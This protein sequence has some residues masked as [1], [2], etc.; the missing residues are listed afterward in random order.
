MSKIVF[1]GA[2]SGFGQ[3]LC[4]D[5]LAH[6]ELREC[7]ICLVDTNERHLQSVHECVTQMI[8][9]HRL[10]ATVEAT[11]DRRA[12]LAGADYVVIAV[13]IGGPA[14]DGVPYYHEITIPARY[15]IYQEVGDTLGPGGVFRTLRS[16]PELMRMAQDIGEL[17]PRAWVL[18]YTNPMAALTWVMGATAPLNLV[19]LCHSVQGTA[20]QLAGFLGLPYS[21]VRYWVAGINHMSWFLEFTHDGE[22]LYPR[23]RQAMEDPAIY[24]KE[25]VR[26]EIMRHFGYFV[27]ES[28]RHM[29][30]YVPYFRKSRELLSEFGLNLREVGEV[31]QDRRWS[32]L[33]E[34]KQ[35]LQDADPNQDLKPS[36]EYASYI[37]KAIETNKPFRFNGNVM[38]GGLI[39]NLPP[40]CCVEVPCL[41]DGSGVRPCYVGALPTHLAALNASNVAVQQLMVQACLEQSREK[42]YHAVAL[43]PLTAGQCTLAQIRAMF[44]ELWEAD[45]PWLEW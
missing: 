9:S 45:K 20:S 37:M 30:E 17:C 7:H 33:Q 38:N 15:G 34:I 13:A 14:Y 39:S 27:T 11:T 21:E 12:V 8:E 43:D 29:S 24:K 36:G 32:W 6:P 3:R 1:I 44:D 35:Q 19:G 10:P 16:A 22:D 2:G 26:F 40:D 4:N 31:A 25:P 23:L 42:A 41:T 18:N 5:I 28:T